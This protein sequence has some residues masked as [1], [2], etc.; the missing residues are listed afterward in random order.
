MWELEKLLG[1]VPSVKEELWSYGEMEKLAGWNIS[2]SYS[3]IV[4]S[5]FEQLRERVFDRAPID[6]DGLIS[7]QTY[8]ASAGPNCCISPN[9]RG[10]AKRGRTDPDA[11][12]V[13]SVAPVIDARSFFI[14]SV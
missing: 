11:T 3:T 12:D 2:R 5:M 1:V 9:Q 8:C 7:F 13:H 10:Q 4:L 14:P 6:P